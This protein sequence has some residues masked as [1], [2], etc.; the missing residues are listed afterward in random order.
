MWGAHAGP[1]AAHERPMRVGW[2]VGRPC[3]AAGVCHACLPASLGHRRRHHTQR[4]SATSSTPTQHMRAAL[5]CAQHA[6]TTGAHVRHPRM[7]PEFPCA[8]HAPRCSAA[9]SPTPRHMHH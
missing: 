5:A 3:C 2:G 8:A 7:R 6:F 9:G 4:H 1:G